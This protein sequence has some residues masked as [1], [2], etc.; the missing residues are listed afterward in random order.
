MA[1]S[2]T[3]RKRK[4]TSDTDVWDA[5]HPNNWT[6][7]KLREKLKQMNIVSPRSFT[8]A[9]LLQLYRENSDNV[10]A[11]RRNPTLT[12]Q[13]QSESTVEGEHTCVPDTRSD[14][15]ISPRLSGDFMALQQ[16]V[17]RLEQIILHRTTADRGQPPVTPG[18]VTSGSPSADLMTTSMQSQQPACSNQDGGGFPSTGQALP[19]YGGTQT[20]GLLQTT[21]I[22]AE[23]VP[24]VEIIAPTIRQQ[25]IEGKDINLSTLL[26]PEWDASKCGRFT[27]LGG[28][29]YQ[30]QTDPRL[31][32]SLTLAEFIKAFSIY[33]NVM[34]ETF[35]NRRQE[36][37]A[38]ERDIVEL[39]LAFPGTVFYEYHKAF[40]AKAA[41]LLHQRQIKINWAIRDNQLY[42]TICSGYRCNSCKLCNHMSH[43]EEFCPL[44]LNCSA[45]LTRNNTVDKTKSRNT[46]KDKKGRPRIMKDGKEICNNFNDKG[47]TNSA[48]PYLHIMLSETGQQPKKKKKP[49]DQ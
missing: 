8:K 40:S 31:S 6:A 36:L 10:P 47:C 41:A 19:V 34:C 33:K 16:H 46:D 43:T 29:S 32:K 11:L 48:C 26:M 1:S 37:D 38:Y 4:S 22:S 7:S 39:A 35:P 28:R 3:G 15:S 12:Q 5:N 14:P 24:S 42:T 2:T 20:S 18:Q 49:S 44:L 9:Q 13:D 21:G 25:I 23:S 17:A 45:G 30:L 27:D